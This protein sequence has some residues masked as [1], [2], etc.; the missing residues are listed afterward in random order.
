MSKSRGN[1]KNP[2][3]SD[4][5]L[6]MRVGELSEDGK[7]IVAAIVEQM[8]EKLEQLRAEFR[9]EM[10]D[11]D[12]QISELH[13][14]V[15]SLKM[16]LSK[17]DERVDDADAYERRDTLIFSGSGVPLSRD[18]ESCPDIVCSLVKEKLKVQLSTSDISTCHRLGRKPVTQK[19]D[20]R[21]IIVKLCR[22]DL[23]GDLLFACRELKPDIYVNESLTPTRNRIMYVLRRARQQFPEKISGSSSRDGRVMVWVKP[24]NSEAVGARN[25]RMFINTRLE[26]EN[27]CTE[28]L[29]TPLSTFVENWQ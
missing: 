22:R 5:D 23:K 29:G 3:S 11:K 7:L 17:V 26:L 1:K 13:D 18:Q 28:T 25:S 10:A 27:F 2:V 24:P 20:S 14:E 9:R 15:N 6:E 4:G 8:E 19:P 21:S 12:K 16:K